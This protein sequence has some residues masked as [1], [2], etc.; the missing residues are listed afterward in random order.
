VSLDDLNIGRFDIGL[1]AFRQTL[2]GLRFTMKFSALV[3]VAGAVVPAL[4]IPQYLSTRD[5]VPQEWIAPAPSDCEFQDSHGP[6]YLC[7][8]C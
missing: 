1:F 8:L 6:K 3:A 5:F 4:A 2:H 7:P